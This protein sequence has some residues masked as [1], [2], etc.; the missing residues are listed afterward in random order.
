MS[1]LPREP[2]PGRPRQTRP[3]AGIGVLQRLRRS[4]SGAPALQ[5]LHPATAGLAM[6]PTAF[7]SANSPSSPGI[8][9]P[10]RPPSHS[11][12]PPASRVARRLPISRTPRSPPR[13]SSSPFST[14]TPKPTSSPSSAS[15][16]RTSAASTSPISSHPRTP[17]TTTRTTRPT[18][19][20]APTTRTTTT[21]TTT[22]WTTTRT[23]STTCVTTRALPVAAG[24]S[25]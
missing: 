15:S 21:R 10:A 8:P 3:H 9:H 22:T 23:T 19:T 13:L 16:V 6:A 12:S 17:S 11:T 4:G 5:L 20:T 2:Y 1:K 14:I 18:R 25:A 24:R 7:R